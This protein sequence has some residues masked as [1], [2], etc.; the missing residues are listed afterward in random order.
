MSDDT[1]RPENE[2]ASPG[3]DLSGLSELSLGPQ[4]G[5]GN[6]P[7]P[8]MP[9]GRSRD[10]DER[11][12]GAPR[13]NEGGERRG[14]PR[15]RRGERPARPREEGAP[16]GESRGPRREGRG[17][18]RRDDR[19]GQRGPAMRTET[20]FRPVLD[21]DFYP[22]DAAFK[23]LT[24]AIKTSC[25]TFELFEIA[26][27]ILEKPERWVCVARHPQQ[28]EGE[29]ALLVAA[30]K[31][32]LPF[33]N[34]QA[35]LNHVFA[36]YLGDFFE[37]E[38][39]ESDPPAGN[40]QMVHRCG[41]TGELLAPP[42]YHRYAAIIRDH[43]ANRLAHVP[44][45][46]FQQRIESL[47][48]EE[49]IQAWLEKMKKRV[50][51]TLKAEFVP[52]EKEAPVF[53]QV[54]DARIY[55]IA[56][57]KDKLVRPAYSVR[58]VGKDLTL[59]PEGDIL[60][61][62]IEALHEQQMRFP[63]STANNLRG[64]LRRLNFAV[65]KKGSKGVSYVCAV[66]RRFREPNEVLAENLSD[67]IAFVE[68]HP[69]LK[70]AD[71]PH[72][73]LGLAAEPA[74]TGTSSAAANLQEAAGP[75]EESIHPTESTA[76]DN[77]V[78][79]VENEEAVA[80]PAAEVTAPE[81]ESAEQKQVSALRR[82]LRYLVTQGYVIE[83]SDGRLVVPPAR[84][85]PV[86]AGTTEKKGRKKEKK[87]GDPAPNADV[88]TKAPDTADVPSPSDDGQ[89]EGQPIAEASAADAPEAP[90]AEAVAPDEAASSDDADA[91]KEDEPADE[92]K[93]PS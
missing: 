52:Q 25:R 15:D 39:Y 45:E 57:H 33:L 47:R 53:N 34:E 67:L 8:K 63:L 4:W 14:P 55:L 89:A 92:T 64:R 10:H 58:I 93:P 82:D 38:E 84:E 72:Q 44:F 50:R 65:Y 3:L 29:E 32:G 70:A 46:R 9:R 79:A 18:P 75:L 59:L 42:N 83:Y 22:D 62:S 43:H 66:K 91:V 51:Y 88:G 71:L 68:A 90:A 37:I 87:K 12:R 69:N 78:S 48:E 1:N 28:K 19:G 23:A 77:T 2:D 16:S 27:L 36:H 61:R 30:I 11:P 6:L 7:E 49:A 56:Q 26:H 85:E 40:F 13:R 73:Y 21:A 60:R 35:A 24:H 17:A 86:A 76:D 54:E 20:P 81:S 5:S 74:A 80:K 31:D 41:M